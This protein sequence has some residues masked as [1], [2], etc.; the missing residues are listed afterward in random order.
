MTDPKD[1]LENILEHV[2]VTATQDERG[3]AN[4]RKDYRMR[5]EEI[6]ALAKQQILTHYISYE[7][8]ERLIPEKKPLL[9]D[10]PLDV[11]EEGDKF[12]VECGQWEYEGVLDCKCVGYNQAIA[13][14]KAALKKRRESK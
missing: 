4:N 11:M 2:Y 1:P 14:L 12:C 6:P 9:T 10:E 3:V 13:E 7:E 5:Y 8:L